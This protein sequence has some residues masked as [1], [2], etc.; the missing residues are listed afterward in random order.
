MATALAIPDPVHTSSF[1]PLSMSFPLQP[2][3][4]L[5]AGAIDRTPV[6]NVKGGIRLYDYDTSCVRVTN[7]FLF[8]SLNPNLA[9]PLH[10][11]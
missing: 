5:G 3:S 8:G 11:L 2:L 10:F 9:R 1:S 7:L 6:G 4:L